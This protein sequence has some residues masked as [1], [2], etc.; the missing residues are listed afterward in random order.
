MFVGVGWA[1]HNDGK[2]AS[3]GVN[4]GPDN[5]VWTSCGVGYIF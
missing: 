1:M 2:V 5:M 4:L 3:N